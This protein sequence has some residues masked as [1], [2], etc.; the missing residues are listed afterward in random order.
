MYRE[1]SNTLPNEDDYVVGR[2]FLEVRSPVKAFWQELLQGTTQ[3][4][5]PIS[6]VAPQGADIQ[7]LLVTQRVFLP[8]LPPAGITMAT[9]AKAAWSFVVRKRM[10][11]S[12]V[13][14]TQVING[15]DSIATAGTEPVFGACHSITPL[16]DRYGA[17]PSKQSIRQLLQDLQKQYVQSLPYSAIDWEYMVNNCTSWPE[18][19]QIGFMMSYQDMPF[20]EVRSDDVHLRTGWECSGTILPGEAWVITRPEEGDLVVEFYVST[21]VMAHEEADAWLSDFDQVLKLF[22]GSPDALLE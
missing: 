2:G 4:P 10:G 1:L 14:L 16:C 19:A 3:P 6:S 20:P 12:T 9:V 21:T 15:R 22:L 17:D 18:K 5:L 7:S 11:I 8:Q 13:V